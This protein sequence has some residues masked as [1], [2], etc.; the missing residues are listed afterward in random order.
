MNSKKEKNS[1]PSETISFYDKLIQN[2]PLVER[3][4]A[5]LPYTSFNGHMFSFIDKGGVLSLRLP[6]KE[7]EAFIKKYKTSLSIQHGVIMK[8][9]VIVP[10]KLFKKTTELL[11]YFEASLAY[12]QT[13]KPK[14]K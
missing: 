3:K 13:L 9:Y 14:K 4:G 6:E 12:I 11:K 7:R 8:E 5:T 1:V 2:N 10:E